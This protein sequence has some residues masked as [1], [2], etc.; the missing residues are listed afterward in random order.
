MNTFKSK[1]IVILKMIQLYKLNGHSL[2]CTN[3]T[4]TKFILKA[5]I[6]LNIYVHLK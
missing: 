3:Y 4:S 5:D 1:Y 6:V 2:L